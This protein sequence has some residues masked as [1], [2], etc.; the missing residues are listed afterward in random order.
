MANKTRAK[1]VWDRIVDKNTGHIHPALT[2]TTQK[3]TSTHNKTGEHRCAEYFYNLKWYEILGSSFLQL[4]TIM[5]YVR[6]IVAWVI[7]RLGMLA[8]WRQEL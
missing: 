3:T 8:H 7:Y 4:V 2:R 5:N 1:N 6:G